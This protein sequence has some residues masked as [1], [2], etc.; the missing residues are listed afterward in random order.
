MFSF[1]ILGLN[2]RGCGDVTIP[3]SLTRDPV[4]D[5]FCSR[6]LVIIPCEFILDS[7]GSLNDTSAM[8]CVLLGDGDDFVVVSLLL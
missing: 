8:V 2:S 7:V 4:G 6:C 5:N 1:F 3:N